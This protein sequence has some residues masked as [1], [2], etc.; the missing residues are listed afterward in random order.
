M[1]HLP[2]QPSRRPAAAVV[3][4]PIRVRGVPAARVVDARASLRMRGLRHSAANDRWDWTTCY[5]AGMANM[6]SVTI[7]SLL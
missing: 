5:D 4:Q 2:I 7:I 1:L 6:G 3:V